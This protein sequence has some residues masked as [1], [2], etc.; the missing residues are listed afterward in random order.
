MNTSN[1][2]SFAPAVRRQLIEAVG[3][4]LDIVLAAQ[5]SDLRTTYAEQVA[6]LGRLAKADRTALI[7]R[8]A[9]T[10]FNRLAALRYLDARRWHPF[11]ASVL[12]PATPN[13]TQPELMKLM[14][15]G[16]LPDEL[17]RHANVTRLNDLLAGRIPSNDAQAEVYRTLVLAA[18]R[19]Y[20]ALL[21]ELFERLDDET[22]LLLPD[23]LLTDHSIAHGF[24]TSISEEDCA[25][26]EVL[27]WLYQFYI[28]EKKDQVMARK[29]AVPSEDIPAVTQLFT[30]HW[31][32]R[33]LV[34][35]SLGRLWMLNHPESRLREQMPYYIG[36]EPET[37]FL[38]ISSP[39]EI[40]LIDPAV[41][42]GHMLTYAFDLLYA[43]YEEE[44]YAPSEIPGLILK[45]NLYGVD[46]DPRAAQLASLALVLKARERSSSFLRP[47]QLVHPN[48]IAMQDVRFEEQELA[49]YV[50]ALDLGDLFT[51]PV[52]DLLKQFEHASTFGS[53]IQPVL[54]EGDVIALRKRIEQSSVGSD[55]FL[56]ET[57]AKVLRVLETAQCLS[58]RYQ[59]AVANP[60]Y[61][62]PAAMNPL[63]KEF[64]R[65]A[66]SASKA[67]AFAMMLERLQCLVVLRG[68]L[69][70]VTMQAWM[71]TA[72][73]EQLRKKILTGS[74][75]SSA[76][77][78][79]ARAFDSISGEVV[80]TVAF[81]VAMVR[82]HGRVGWF[83]DLTLGRSEV[84][85]ERSL[86][87]AA[88]GELPQFVY[89]PA[90][91][92]FLALPGVPLAYWLSDSLLQVFRDCDSLGAICQPLKGM[93]TSDNGRFLRAW[94][95]V[96]GRRIGFNCGSQT[97]ALASGRKW[98]PYSKGG[99]YRKW[100]GNQLW[101]VNW[102][103]GGQEVIKYAA[104]LY[105]A[106]SR[107][108]QNVEA[109]FK[110]CV[111]WSEVGAGP[112]AGREVPAGFIFDSTG[113]SLFGPSRS[114]SLALSLLCSN[115]V[116]AF[117]RVLNP[118]LHMTV[119]NVAALP[120]P[121]DRLDAIADQVAELVSEAVSVAREDWSLGETS[122]E[123]DRSP[124]LGPD[125]TGN[126][127]SARWVE[128]G[129]DRIQKVATLRAVETANN[130]VW[131][132]AYRLHEELSPE[133]VDAEITL[134][135][136]DRRRDL[137]A[138]VSYAVG[139]MMGRYSLDKPGLILA[140][141]GDTLENYLA[142]VGKPLEEL[143]FAPDRDGIVPVLD[144]EWFEDDIVARTRDFLRATFGD[145][146]LNEN[147]RF[148]E[149][150]L[151]KDL[152]KYFTT[153]FYKDH[154]QTY[155]KR[156]I[157]WM[158]QSPKKGFSALI[159]LHR[160]TKDTMNIVLNRYLREY[161]AKLRDSIAH[162]SRVQVN[163]GLPAKEK[164]AARKESDRL[165]KVL[166]ECQEWERSTLLPLAQQ[167]I[168]LDLDDG[169]K[170]NYL[171]LG[172]A[173]APIPGLAAKGED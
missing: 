18:C 107:Q 164:T 78:L 154:Q 173:L 129:A 128:W 136:P 8:V 21:P 106:A 116:N 36:G 142:K 85:K 88:A 163:E 66:Y 104:D 20:H 31:I 69:A 171:K 79:G 42:S 130:K 152:R 4:K 57:N 103:N 114:R 41:G 132:E 160:Y 166:Q 49:A 13:E 162:L 51:Q 143:T 86:V 70:S 138:F 158:V 39:E 14:L 98:F 120:V 113:P 12:M 97:E 56:A 81:V 50:R 9:Y 27:G 64:A 144:G 153:D 60:P 139:C 44:G 118:T 126:S 90:V 157:Y 63:L 38:R 94:F 172:A 53:L 125:L 112:L 52:V 170:V 43:I 22:E 137:A 6:S 109:Y 93:T 133:V 168:E 55:V 35:N 99:E 124:L 123:F 37:E 87:A 68:N 32:V 148:L 62:G 28:S 65:Q 54:G 92:N 73:F 141:A 11:R 96:S 76:I 17:A 58:Q 24:R 61:L 127:V 26:V 7:E 121:I 145:D 101:V 169:V 156:P 151:G 74:F 161:A 100:Y 165:T 119:R 19:Y 71:F 1:L 84:D 117:A 48:I 105:G 80:Q 155:K 108:I 10:W 150:S 46:I 25:E 91:E 47:E 16:T 29:S 89:R 3:R 67:D 147:L 122:W 131:I 135:R 34:E 33:Y 95:E 77:H 159:Y 45:H 23:D 75:I 134:T 110:P 140:D 40:R 83:A 72:S 149:E 59:I 102:E 115:V 167:R 82:P 15:S 2:K 30:P 5:S 111:T 146:T